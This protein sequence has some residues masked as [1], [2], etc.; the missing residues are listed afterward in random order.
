MNRGKKAVI[1]TVCRKKKCLFTL[2][3]WGGGVKLKS[4]QASKPLAKALRALAK[5]LS[6]SSARNSSLSEPK[7][8]SEERS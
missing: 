7:A 4:T 3:F 1:C 5:A 2:F 6:V 8:N